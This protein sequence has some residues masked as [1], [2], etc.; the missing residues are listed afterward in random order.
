MQV[1]KQ[2]GSK[3]VQVNQKMTLKQVGAKLNLRNPT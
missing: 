1:G 3:W 2:V